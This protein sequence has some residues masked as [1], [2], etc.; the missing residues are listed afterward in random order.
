MV[1]YKQRI[2]SSLKMGFVVIV[3]VV[4]WLSHV[5]LFVTLRT[6]AEQASLTFTISWSL[7]KLI[8][9]ELMMPSNHLILC[10]PLLLLSSIFPSVRV[11]SNESALCIRWPKYWSFSFVISPSNGYSGLLFFRIDWSD[12]LSKEL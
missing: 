8:S 3:V 6:A 11:F 7:L 9:I 12:F 5:R 10:H 1:I 4:Q 2:T